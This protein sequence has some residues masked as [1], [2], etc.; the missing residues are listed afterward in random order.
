M[1]IVVLDGF[2]LNPGDLSWD[3]LRALGAC[4][5][6]DRTPAEQTIAR[7][8]SAQVVLTNK[9]RLDRRSLEA[10]PELRYV[11]VLATGY[12][13]VDAQAA[14][15]RGIPVTNVPAYGTQSVAQMVFAHVLNLAGHVAEHAAGVRDGRWAAS[16]DFCYWDFPLVELDGLTMGL[17]GLGRIGL[18]VARIAQAFGMKVLACDV[19]SVKAP[20]G[21]RLAD[22]DTVFA[23][24]DVVSLHCPLTADTR[25]LVNADR[26]ALMK[27]TA[28]L[29]NTARGPLV[30]QADL[31]AA[32]EAGRI[33]GA[34]L[35]VLD[36]EP[37][38]PDNPLPKARNC[39]VSPHVAWATRAARARLM[40][41]A[42]NNVKAFIAGEP[43]NVVNA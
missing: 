6:H 32:L 13:V 7:A 23:E 29:I 3:P 28:F 31:A 19:E 26:L 4:Q 30:N 37:P 25:G 24:A 14:R 18:A 36:G 17:V 41:T 20:R 10:L 11:G 1:N 16:P 22:L 34:G 33:A 27:P 12:D 40:A 15:Q 8:A 43:T 38:A 39:Y 2:T 5:V 21:V 42:V 9:T 35:D